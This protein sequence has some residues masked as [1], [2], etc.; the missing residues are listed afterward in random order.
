MHT[1]TYTPAHIHTTPDPKP[2]HYMMRLDLSSP[3]DWQEVTP[4]VKSPTECFFGPRTMAVTESLL[5]VHCD[6]D[7]KL[8]GIF[9]RTY[10]HL[11]RIH[12]YAYVKT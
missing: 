2:P 9:I 1:Y 8:Q 3:V 7:L 4:S 10:V 6:R 5:V 12:T 11:I